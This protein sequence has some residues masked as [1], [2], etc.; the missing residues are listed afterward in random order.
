MCVPL[1]AGIAIA[2]LVMTAASTAVAAY[3]SY[4]QQ[5]S[6]NAAAQ[7]NADIQNRNAQV[8]NM[9]AD[10]I[11]QQGDIAAKQKRLEV[12]QMEGTQRAT[13]AASGML[14]DSG[15]F[16][17]IQ[18]DTAGYGELDALQT[19]TNY[20]LQSWAK[21]NQS[22]NYTAQASLDDFSSHT[23][24]MLGAGASL[25]SGASRMASQTYTA[26]KDGTFS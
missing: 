11:D 4:Q 5:K 23:S 21:R 17:N 2:G 24:P 16:G 13:G 26:E 15:S 7:Y 18:S 10:R 12:A 9:E 3:S 8:A 22:A 14:V 1:V 19:K 20:S 6:A 25:L